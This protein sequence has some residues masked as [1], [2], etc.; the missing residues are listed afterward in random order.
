MQKRYVIGADIGGSHIS[1][2]VIDLKSE[3][4]ITGSQSSYKVDKNGTAKAIIDDWNIALEESLS[5][6]KIEQLAGIGLAIPG[7]FDYE[8]GIALFDNQNAKFESLNG[9]NVGAE[10]MQRLNLTDKTPI[11]FINDATAFAVGEAWIGKSVGHKRS[12]AITLGTGF[13]SAFI[14][15]GVPVLDRADVPRLGCVWHLPYK[16]GIADDYFS[17]RWFIN[18]YFQLSGNALH[19]VKEIAEVART[20]SEAARLFEEFGA[21]LGEFMAPWISVFDAQCI[22]VGGNM[23]GAFDLWGPSLKSALSNRGVKVEIELS[24]LM[25]TSAMVGGARLLNDNFWRQISPLLSKM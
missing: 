8:K 22:V 5:K 19:G 6:F 1:T 10:L 7:P 17:T 11:R 21:N 9:V 3:S 24:E 15:D 23:I 13:G 25:E 16:A 20:S 2:V 4:V 12:I 14:E 18:R